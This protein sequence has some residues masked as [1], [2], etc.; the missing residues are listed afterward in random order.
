[1]FHC[2]SISHHTTPLALR[3]QLSLTTDQ[4]KQW[5]AALPQGE[6]AILSTC[7]RLE[8]YAFTPTEAGMD[9][10]WHSLLARR[11]IEPAMIAGYTVSASGQAAVR[12]LFRVSSGLESMALGEPQIVGQVTRAYEQ[13]HAQDAAGHMLSLLFRAAIHTAKRVRTETAIG[14]GAA[15]ISSLGIGK[16]E[17]TLG[18]LRARP[19]LV[20]GAGEMAQAIVKALVQRGATQITIVSRTYDAAR[21]LA[22]EWQVRA[23]SITELKDALI[24]ADVVFTT[25]SAPFTILSREDVEPLMPLR[26]G[27][28][29][30]LIDLAVPRDIE[31]E[32][33]AILGVCLHDMDDLQGVIEE[34]LAGRQEQIPAVERIIDE[35]LAAFWADIQAQAVIPTIRQLREQAEQFRQ[36]ELSRILNRLPSEDDHARALVEQFSHRLMNKLLHQVTLNLKEKAAHDDGALF[37]AVAR[38]LFGLED[39]A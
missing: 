5:L 14:A 35:E 28:G 19:V 15:S 18:S 16:A 10:L 38:D 34:S 21:S 23:R 25:S 24:E 12:H 6:A 13:A 20:I 7:N 9:D 32:V 17:H 4:Q 1:M 3:E 33:G 22:D 27:R 39:S 30:C 29:L 36:A 8:L 26:E 2:R 37:A 31:P 11:R